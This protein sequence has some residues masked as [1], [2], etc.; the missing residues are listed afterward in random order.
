MQVVG[1][2]SS[3]PRE[4][5]EGLLRASDVVSVC[6]PLS[7][8]TRGLIGAAELALMKPDAVLVNTARGDIIDKAALVQVRACGVARLLLGRGKGGWGTSGVVGMGARVCVTGLVHFTAPRPRG[9][10]WDVLTSQ[11]PDLGG[12][13]ADSSVGL[14]V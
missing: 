14:R 1:T 11:P 10:R 5:L 13:G 7:E 3:S 6:C 2:T 8:A 4:V 9:G 12:V